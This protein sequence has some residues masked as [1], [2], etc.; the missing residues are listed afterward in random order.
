MSRNK[1]TIM[2]RTVTTQMR[3]TSIGGERCMHGVVTSKLQTIK[4]KVMHLRPLISDFTV[5]GFA[6]GSMH[7][8]G[9]NSTRG[10]ATCTVH[11]ANASS[12]C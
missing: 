10:S 3:E 6:E 2:K 11:R 9:R 12:R 7:S 4:G 8:D 1:R 5:S